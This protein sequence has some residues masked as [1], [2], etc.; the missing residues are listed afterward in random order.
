MVLIALVIAVAMKIVGV[1]LIT[2]MLIIPA[3]TAQRLART[4]EQMAVGASIIQSS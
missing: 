1:L 3:A 4:P 2:A